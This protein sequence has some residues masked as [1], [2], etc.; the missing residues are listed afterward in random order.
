MECGSGTERL[1]LPE[2][3]ICPDHV[4]ICL[5][6]LVVLCLTCEGTNPSMKIN[7]LKAVDRDC[8]DRAEVV[9]KSAY[10]VDALNVGVLM[11]CC[12]FLSE[13]SLCSVFY[14]V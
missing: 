11:K 4:N 8:S 12:C 3:L 10:R 9:S 6:L 1:C 2:H 7:V 14:C 5:H 13:S